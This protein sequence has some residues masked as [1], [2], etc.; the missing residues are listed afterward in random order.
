MR[1][2]FTAWTRDQCVW[3]NSLVDCIVTNG[4]ADHPLAATDKMLIQAEP[5]ALWAIQKPHRPRCWPPL[6]QAFALPVLQHMP[7]FILPDDLAFFGVEA[8]A[9]PEGTEVAV[10]LGVAACAAQEHAAQGARQALA[11]VIE[12]VQD[13]LHL[14]DIEALLPLADDH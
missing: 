11:Q 5:Y 9:A 12:H 13:G 4:P 6:P 3:L 8:E 2:A 7:A 14:A 1:P 10:E